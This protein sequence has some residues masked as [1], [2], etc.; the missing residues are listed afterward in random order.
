MR[1]Q[2]RKRF[3]SLH[4][5]L[6]VLYHLL[7]SHPTY[8]EREFDMSFR[9]Y[10][11]CFVLMLFYNRRWNLPNFQLRQRKV[12]ARKVEAFC[13]PH[14]MISYFSISVFYWPD[15]LPALEKQ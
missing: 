12:A 11:L 15:F 7:L 13:R 1:K 9:H 2:P 5:Q 3:F 10:F 6:E 4:S 14:F 8:A